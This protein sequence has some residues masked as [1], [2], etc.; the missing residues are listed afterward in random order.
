MNAEVFGRK[1]QPHGWQTRGAFARSLAFCDQDVIDT[2]RSGQKLIVYSERPPLMQ[3]GKRNRGG[4]TVKAH[5]VQGA[6]GFRLHHDHTEARLI[7]GDRQGG[8]DHPA[9]GNRYIVKNRLSHVAIIAC[10]RR[11]VQPV[12][13]NAKLTAILQV[14]RP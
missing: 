8:P 9:A 11:A 13:V 2:L 14:R 1:L 12:G 3:T 10:G 4:S 7:Q 6:V 5:I